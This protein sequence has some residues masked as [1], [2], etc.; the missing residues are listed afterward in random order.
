MSRPEFRIQTFERPIPTYTATADGRLAVSGLTQKGLKELND[1]YEEKTPVK[2]II[3]DQISG[4]A[5]TSEN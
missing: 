4:G 2:D 3:I 1:L 5:K